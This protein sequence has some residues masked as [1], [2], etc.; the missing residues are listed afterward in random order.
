MEAGILNYTSGSDVSDFDGANN[1]GEDLN[2]FGLPN[3]FGSPL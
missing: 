2:S 3:L 1:S